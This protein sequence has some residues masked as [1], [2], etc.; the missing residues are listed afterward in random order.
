MTLSQNQL[1]RIE[2]PRVECFS[3]DDFERAF[4]L[5]FK[6]DADEQGGYADPSAE[7]TIELNKTAKASD[8]TTGAARCL[9]G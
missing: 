4:G 8:T 1:P 5:R 9:I 3:V 6:S 7:R 2:R